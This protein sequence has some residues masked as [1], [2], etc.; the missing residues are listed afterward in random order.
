MK[1]SLGMS[2][3]SVVSAADGYIFSILTAKFMTEKDAG[4]VFSCVKTIEVIS[5]FMM[6]VTL[7]FSRDF[8]KCIAESDSK[9][10]Q[11]K[12]NTAVLLQ[13]TPVMFCFIFIVIFSKEVLSVFGSEYADYSELLN[14]M[15]LGMLINTLSGSTVSLMQLGNLHWQHVYLQ[16]IAIIIGCISLPIFTFEF[17]VVGI[18]YSYLL[19]KVL[20]NVSAVIY[21][22]INL[23]VD[24]SILSIITN[25]NSCNS[26][27]FEDIKGVK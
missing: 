7:V 16:L 15:A 18:G 20:W 13:A 10:L 3:I 26:Y 1:A 8:S 12:C 27:I 11:R 19:T 23:S 22:R 24:P 4:A 25:Y 9:L 21:I 5:I 2:I 17:D 14:I 6:A